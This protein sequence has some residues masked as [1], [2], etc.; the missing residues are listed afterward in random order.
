[1]ALF[2]HKK[3]EQFWLSVLIMAEVTNTILN[4]RGYFITLKVLLVESTP[5][6]SQ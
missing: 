3:N 2:L 6:V 4:K 1:M 5:Y